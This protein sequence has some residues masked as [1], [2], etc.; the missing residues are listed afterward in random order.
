M[1]MPNRCA[2]CLSMIFKYHY[3]LKFRVFAQ[4]QISFTIRQKNLLDLFFFHCSYCKIMLWMFYQDFMFSN[5]IHPAEKMVNLFSFWQTVTDKRGKFIWNNS[6]PPAR[7]IWSCPILA[8][9][10]YLRWGLT[11][12]PF[13]KRTF[14]YLLGGLYFRRFLGKIFRAPSALGCNYN[15]LF[16]RWILSKLWHSNYCSISRGKRGL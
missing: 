15:P 9:G 8:I 2:R 10:K 14:F 7:R 1:R 11:F 13:A 16:C 4:I 6:Y 12:M 5:P 3:K